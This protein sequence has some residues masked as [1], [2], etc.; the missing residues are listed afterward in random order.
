MK[1]DAE[2]KKDVVAE[3][4]WD[5]AVVSTAIGVAVDDGVV[6]VSGHLDTYA[7][8]FAVERALRRVHGVQA[9]ALELDVKLS[10]QHK[11]SDTEIA[12]AAEHAL[13]WS[14]LLPAEKIRVTVE[15]G[16]VTLQGEV[17]WE[18]ERQSIE[19]AIRPLI[20]VV[21]ISNQ[22]TLK[23]RPIPADISDRIANALQ[24][25]AMHDA[26]RV[27]IDVDGSTVTLQGQVHSWRERNA[28]QSA[29]WSAPGVRSVDNELR[30][31]P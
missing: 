24:R 22:I 8:K 20:G 12:A 27:Q 15:N 9:I 28:I 25:Q 1:T 17:D 10:P 11:R 14:S 5:P 29:V 30:V 13:K 6:T 31:A 3:L 21:E 7:Q 18:Y 19:K 16:H 4:S 2:L 23:P 26:K